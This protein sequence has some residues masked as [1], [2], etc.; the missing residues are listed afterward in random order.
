MK[1]KTCCQNVIPNVSCFRNV[2]IHSKLWG[3]WC[4][5]VSLF[6]SSFTNTLFTASGRGKRV[7]TCTAFFSTALLWWEG[8]HLDVLVLPPPRDITSAA[9][10]RKYMCFPANFSPLLCRLHPQEPAHHLLS[11]HSSSD[12]C[13]SRRLGPNSL[14]LSFS[15][16]RYVYFLVHRRLRFTFHSSLSLDV[17]RYIV[18]Q[19]YSNLLGGWI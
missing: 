13:S 17:C 10:L 12:G 15:D 1:F 6:F 2:E 5:K 9:Q 16:F 14:H 7:R 8:P 19:F 4:F 11:S 18:E 3:N